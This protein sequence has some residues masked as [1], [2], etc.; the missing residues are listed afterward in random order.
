MRVEIPDLHTQYEA[1]LDT[2]WRCEARA[3]LDDRIDALTRFEE[4]QSK[5]CS[6][7]L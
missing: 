2:V 6:A 1:L 3:R 4:R 5:R 7:R